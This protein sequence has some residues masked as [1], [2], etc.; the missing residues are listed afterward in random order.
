MDAHCVILRSASL[1]SPTAGS[2]R[3][4]Q[5]ETE[6]R[7]RETLRLICHGTCCLEHLDNSHLIPVLSLESQ[8]RFRH[9]RPLQSIDCKVVRRT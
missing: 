7:G 2:L 4:K 5:F 1:A 6:T 3:D 8:R 9:L